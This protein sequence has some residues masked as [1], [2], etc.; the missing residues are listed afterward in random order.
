MG[1]DRMDVIDAMNRMKI[2]WNRQDRRM[3]RAKSN[4]Q[5]QDGQD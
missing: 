1:Y 3:D 4:K 5:R 2:E